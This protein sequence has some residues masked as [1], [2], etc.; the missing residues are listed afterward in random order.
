MKDARG[1]G[2]NPRGIAAMHGISTAHLGPHKVQSL[3]TGRVGQPWATQKAYGNKTVAER[4]AMHM[5][6]DGGYMRVRTRGG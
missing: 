5:R 2:S 3:D 1:H 4:V 6:T